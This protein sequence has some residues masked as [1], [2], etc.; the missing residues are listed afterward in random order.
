MTTQ[1]P[2]AALEQAVKRYGAHLALDQVSLRIERGRVTALLGPNGAGKS[3]VINLLLGLL[4]SDS[5]HAQLFGESPSNLSARRRVGLMLQSTALPDTLRVRE[6]L[7]LTCSYYPRPLTLADVASLAGIEK[8]L[9]RFYGRLS[10][11]E[12]RRVQFALAL[13]GDPELLFLDEP[14]TGMDIEARTALWHAIRKL[15]EQGRTVLLTTH[16]L[17]EAEALA[18]HV[19]VLARGRIVA[20]DS[21]DVLRARHT[22]QQVRCISTLSLTHIENWPEV[23]DARREEQW[24]EIDTSAVEN[25]VRRLLN[26]DPA[27]RELQVTRAT[28]AEAFLQITQAAA[29]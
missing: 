21:V 11:G 18:D 3:T 7:Q 1:I 20:Q 8:L 28:L 9:S 17:E 16:Y 27:L 10:G 6:L 23:L 14:T 19:A 4:E 26:D 2:A 12:Q 5:G 13:C 15:V 24:L 25:L 29:A 22:S